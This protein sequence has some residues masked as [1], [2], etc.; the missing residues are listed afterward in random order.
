MTLSHDEKSPAA[1][2]IV[3]R[4]AATRRNGSPDPD[5]EGDVRR[6]RLPTSSAANGV[7]PPERR[8]PR[9]RHRKPALQ[10]FDGRL[11]ATQR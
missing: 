3:G 1:G 5:P 2:P 9:N 8:R 11:T 4:L 7:P 10:A 6:R